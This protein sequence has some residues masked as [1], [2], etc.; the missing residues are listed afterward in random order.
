MVN[1]LLVITALLFFPLSLIAQ[2]FERQVYAS[3]GKETSNQT[4]LYTQK[5]FLTYTIGEPIIKGATV[6]T[7]ILSNGFIQP[8]GIT[9]INPPL[10]TAISQ[11]PEPFSIYP[12]PFDGFITIEAPS[13]NQ[14]TVNV[15]LID[16]NGKLIREERMESKRLRF[17]IPPS[18]TAGS[19]FINI[20]HVNGTFIQQRK[21]V[22]TTTSNSSTNF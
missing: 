6:A 5:K 10:A 11:A 18:T 15:Q 17:D 8:I 9:F 4:L 22:K 19:Y 3:A 20:Y 1:N 21:M 14:D 7:R 12:N 16:M 2:S 13:E